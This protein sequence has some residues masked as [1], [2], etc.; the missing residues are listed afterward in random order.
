MLLDDRR[1]LSDQFVEARRADQKHA[2]RNGL[3]TRVTRR[4]TDFEE[5]TR[6]VG[7]LP[8]S[9]A[10]SSMVTANTGWTRPIPSQPGLVVAAYEWVDGRGRKVSEFVRNLPCAAHRGRSRAAPCRPGTRPAPARS[11]G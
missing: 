2:L 10:G 5:R 8:D 11:G 1:I 4:T 7:I 9:L 6:H 3:E